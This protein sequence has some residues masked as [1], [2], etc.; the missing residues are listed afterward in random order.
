MIKMGLAYD[1]S[2]S[3]MSFQNPMSFLET[4]HPLARKIALS[5]ETASFRSPI[6][7]K[8]AY[9]PDEPQMHH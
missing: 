5:M 8:D 3:Y 1:S 6:D 2:W 4:R 9:E 7:A